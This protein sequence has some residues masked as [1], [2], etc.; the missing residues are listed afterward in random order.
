MARNFDTT[1]IE[2]FEWDKGNISKNWLKHRVTA[3]ECEEVFFN[4][5]TI[6]F[7]DSKHSMLEKRHGV[8]G[9]TREGRLLAIYFW[10][11]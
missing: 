4:K 3:P 1:K 10:G 5:L 8:L 2:G 11:S 7:K 9:R 6:L